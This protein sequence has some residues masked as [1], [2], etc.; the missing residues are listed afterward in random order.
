MTAGHVSSLFFF[1]ILVTED[2]SPISVV[3]VLYYVYYVLYCL[4]HRRNKTTN[5]QGC[6]IHLKQLISVRCSGDEVLDVADATRQ[7]KVGVNRCEVGRNV[8]SLFK[9]HRMDPWCCY[10]IYI[11][12]AMDPIKKNPMFVSINI[13][14]PWIRHGTASDPSFRHDLFRDDWDLGDCWHPDPPGC[15]RYYPLVNVYITKI[16]IFNG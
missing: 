5:I 2:H 6:I 1:D 12:C 4:I 10:I 3:Y 16:T 11:W 14:A 8:V 13:A 9:T 15:Y 7:R